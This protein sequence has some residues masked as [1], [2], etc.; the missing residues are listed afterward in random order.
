MRE[1]LKRGSTNGHVGQVTPM[2]E[3]EPYLVELILQLAKMR[4]PITS[5]QGLELAN[6]L[7]SGTEME[8]KLVEWKSKNCHAYK[9]TASSDNENG[10]KL[11]IGYWKSFLERNAC[12]H[13]IHNEVMQDLPSK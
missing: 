9:H 13:P 4:T 7:I 5:A 11:S 1:R 3:V 8:D 6:S 2:A 10:K 12:N